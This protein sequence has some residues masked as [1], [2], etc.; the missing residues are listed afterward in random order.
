[1]LL[2][3]FYF[4]YDTVSRIINSIFVYDCLLVFRILFY[5]LHYPI[6]ITMKLCIC[7]YAGCAINLFYII[8]MILYLRA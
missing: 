2:N 5:V 8:S 1:M 4:V 6:L 7:F 3:I